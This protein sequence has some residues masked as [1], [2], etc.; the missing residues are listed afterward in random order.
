MFN[1]KNSSVMKKYIYIL[2]AIIAAL[3]VSSCGTSKK[4]NEFVTNDPY[5]QQGEG[6]S[7]ISGA[8][9]TIK[10]L[11]DNYTII[12]LERSSDVTTT[13]K[14]NYKSTQ[15]NASNPSEKETVERETVVYS[16]VNISDA[17][18]EVTDIPRNKKKS[19]A[20][21]AK[22]VKTTVDNTNVVVLGSDSK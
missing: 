17:V 20:L 19:K 8:N 21:H 4:A 22:S 13:V 11:V 7:N 16:D 1:P 12:G 5:H 3:I 6:Y 10:G 14:T 9:A 18:N 2:T 15:S